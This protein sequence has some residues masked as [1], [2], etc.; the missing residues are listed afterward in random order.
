MPT[1]PDGD[2]V[3]SA[4]PLA[5][6][7]GRFASVDRGVPF[8]LYVH[9]PFCR[10]RCGYCDFNTY[11]SAE[12]GGG[13]DQARY[14]ETA[15]AEMRMAAA[16]MRAAG[17]PERE[18]ASVFFGGGTPTILPA[19]DL[20]AM[21]AGARNEWGIAEGAEVTTEANPDT[22]DGT[23]AQQ[24]ARA[25]FTRVS[26]GMQS[27]VPHVLATLERTHDPANV[28]SAVGAVK[29]AG[30]EVSVDLIYGTPGESL[31]DWKQS[32]EAALAL[33]P[34]H[35]SAYALGIEPGTKMGVQLAR[36][37]I[38]PPDP[39]DQAAKYEYADDAFTAAGYP[40]YEISNW[41]RPGRECRH[42]LA[43]WRGGDWWGIGPGA[44]S[45][46]TGVRFWNVKH[47]RAYADRLAA[48]AWP[49]AAR[50]VLDA[51]EQEFERIMLEVRLREGL[52][53]K[54]FPRE[55]QMRDTV[56]GMVAEGWVEPDAAA[57]GIVALTRTGRL[58]ADA[59]TRELT[60]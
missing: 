47:P 60:D 10:V 51:G 41:A 42:N 35:I 14:S 11:T 34:D 6:V 44:H 49:V 16:A 46:M 19:A 54:T 48:G 24:L 59:I 58:M 20:A 45:H 5:E 4:G 39:D 18:L 56:A 9:V 38:D 8:G 29:E 7:D 3:P 32:V 36:G 12:L 2:A 22:V 30:L 55:R 40:W 21:L 53:L 57:R 15:V 25:G 26:V 50:E 27:A 1:L 31:D 13:A 37:Q 43:Y 28:A 17:L 33:A 52:D 23:Y